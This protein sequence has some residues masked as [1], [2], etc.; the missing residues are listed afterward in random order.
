MCVGLRFVYGFYSKVFFVW[1]IC[2]LCCDVIDFYSTR[3]LG[4]RKECRVL[5]QLIRYAIRI[6]KFSSFSCLFFKIRGFIIYL[7]LIFNHDFKDGLSSWGTMNGLII[8]K[9]S[10]NSKLHYT[11][12]EI[13]N[14]NWQS[15]NFS[16]R[17]F[18]IVFFYV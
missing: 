13:T 17:N 3:M 10:Y 2:Y 9:N 12:F 11:R 16:I 18:H 8:H 1:F 14:K 6:F 4:L 15:L 7:N 5:D